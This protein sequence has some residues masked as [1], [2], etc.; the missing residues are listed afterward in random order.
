MNKELTVAAALVAAT[1]FVICIYGANPKDKMFCVF[2]KKRLK[3][4]L[5]CSKIDLYS[6]K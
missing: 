3:N 2:D 1:I 6:E 4:L 5:F